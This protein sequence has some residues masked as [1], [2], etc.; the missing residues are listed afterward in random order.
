MELYKNPCHTA[1]SLHLAEL[2]ENMTITSLAKHGTIQQS[3][4]RSSKVYRAAYGLHK[5]RCETSIY[6]ESPVQM[7]GILSDYHP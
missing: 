4:C 1:A 5:K 2:G 6:S 7:S 3:G